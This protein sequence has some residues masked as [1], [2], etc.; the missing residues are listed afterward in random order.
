MKLAEV[1][2]ENED[3]EKCI[4]E[5][6]VAFASKEYFVDCPDEEKAGRMG[7][8]ADY[9]RENE[10]DFLDIDGVR[11]NF[12]NGWALARPSNTTPHIKCRMEGDTLEDLKDIEAKARELFGKFDINIEE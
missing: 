3:F 9:L 6:P 10:Y 4:D 8:L 1:V 12:P 2:A 5:L 11:I 7:S